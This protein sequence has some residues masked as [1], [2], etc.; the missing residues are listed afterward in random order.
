MYNNLGLRSSVGIRRP[1]Q[2]TAG[3]PYF[4]APWTKS[5]RLYWAGHRIL[6]LKQQIFQGQ[7]HFQTGEET[8]SPPGCCQG[9]GG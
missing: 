8:I 6:V 7:D 2:E 9:K 3:T 5:L 1:K 4:I